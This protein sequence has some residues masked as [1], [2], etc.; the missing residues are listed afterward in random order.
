MKSS[1]SIVRSLGKSNFEKHKVSNQ[2]DDD[3]FIFVKKTSTLLNTIQFIVN[4]HQDL[5]DAIGFAK[6]SNR[7]QC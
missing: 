1:Y 7:F 5:L 4:P 6:D 3:V 2:I